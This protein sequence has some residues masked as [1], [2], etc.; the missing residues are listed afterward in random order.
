MTDVPVEEQTAHN[1]LRTD[2]T[3]EPDANAPAYTRVRVEAALRWLA[4]E[5]RPPEVVARARPG[6]AESWRY[7]KYG[8]Q[9]P[10]DGP[11]R[12]LAV[13]YF[14][15]AIPLRLALAYL[16]WTLE[17]PARLVVAVGLYSLIAHTPL[18]RF[19]YFP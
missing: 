7:A 3:L 9:A 19:L 15:L 18:G 6:M 8:D 10:G 14:V 4:M 5:F 17:R 16:D 2:E 11:A 1:A 13:L 12:S